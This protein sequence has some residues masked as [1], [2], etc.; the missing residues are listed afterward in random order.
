MEGE[1]LRLYVLTVHKAYK[2]KH[3]QVLH[4]QGWNKWWTMLGNEWVLWMNIGMY[5]PSPIWRLKWV[6]C[7]SIA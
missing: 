5:I 4:K 3:M 7:S 2:S 1:V 6:V